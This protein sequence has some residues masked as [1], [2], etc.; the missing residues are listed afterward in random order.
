MILLLIIFLNL[1]ECWT[2]VGDRSFVFQKCLETC[3]KSNCT[4]MNVFFSR[5]PYYLQLLHWDCSSECRYYCM[6]KTVDAFQKDGLPIPQFNGKWPFIRILGIQ[7]P[8]STL[9]SL[10]NAAC[11]LGIF[12]LRS[13]ILPRVHM[14]YVWH[15]VAIVSLNAWICSIIFHTRDFD[16]TEKLDYYFAFSV[17]CI[18]IWAFLCRVLGTKRYIQTGIFSVIILGI[19]IKH[20]HY[21]HYVKLDYGYNMQVN[22]I[23]GIVNTLCWSVW[24]ILKNKQQSY[25]WKCLFTMVSLSSLLLL[26]L[27][28]FPPLFW[29]LD[30]HAFWHAG[31]IPLAIL[32]TR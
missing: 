19:Y 9:F 20:I 5:Q 25:S 11:C 2:S 8:A 15:V 13:R 17:V 22:V 30:A 29:V 28:D 16:I 7:E 3:L 12:Y 21:L 4:D 27:L 1:Q 14:F 24:A 32:W 18:N 31:T 10:G 6:W 26:E 23:F